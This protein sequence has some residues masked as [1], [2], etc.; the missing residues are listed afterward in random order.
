MVVRKE[1]VNFGWKYVAAA[2]LLML[3][4]VNGSIPTHIQA[5]LNKLSELNTHK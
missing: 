2:R 4:L 3:S 5:V 1:A